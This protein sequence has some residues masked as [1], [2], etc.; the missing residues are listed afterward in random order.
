MEALRQAQE[1]KLVRYL[2]ITGHHRP[3]ALMELIRRFPFDPVLLALNAADRH[4]FSFAEQLPLLAV[5]RQMGII[6]MKIPARGRVL[7]TSGSN[8]E[9]VFT[10]RPVA[11]VLSDRTAAARRSCWCKARWRP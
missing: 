7:S 9:G 1:Q 2:G 10:L 4:H 8:G 5:E 11:A 3:D 6:G